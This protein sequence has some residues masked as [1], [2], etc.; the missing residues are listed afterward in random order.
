MAKFV[1][2]ITAVGQR[3]V[4]LNIVGAVGFSGDADDLRTNL[5]EVHANK[6]SD[7]G[8]GELF[9]NV[10]DAMSMQCARHS[11]SG[12]CGH[13]ARSARGVKRLLGPLMMVEPLIL[14]HRC[15]HL[16]QTRVAKVC[17]LALNP[18]QRWDSGSGNIK[19]I[20]IRGTWVIVNT[21]NTHS[22]YRQRWV[23]VKA[24]NK[25]DDLGSL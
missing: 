8:F 17:C 7:R 14:M 6:V 19:E 12:H 4:A 16:P 1:G 5:D 13:L 23:T 21:S 9:T 15:Y 18:K 3:D 2:D 10:E 11:R 24:S 25:I 22:H 20:K